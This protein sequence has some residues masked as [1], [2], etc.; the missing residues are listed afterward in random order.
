MPTA[1]PLFF[2]CLLVASASAQ[3]DAVPTTGIQVEPLLQ[4]LQVALAEERWLDATQSFETV[5]QQLHVQEDQVPGVQFDGT[6]HLQPGEHRSRAGARSQLRH[7]FQTAPLAFRQEYQRQYD[8]S[9]RR[10]IQSALQ[11]G[12]RQSVEALVSRYELCESSASAIRWLI[13]DAMAHGNWMAA[14]L[15]IQRLTAEP[16][17]ASPAMNLLLGEVWLRAGL[18]SE[19]EQAVRSA[20]RQAGFGAT[21]AW[22][23]R[24]LQLPNSSEAVSGWLAAELDIPSAGRSAQLSDQ[25]GIPSRMA[26]AWEISTFQSA[27]QPQLNDQLQL[28]ERRVLALTDNH[29][30]SPVRPLVVNDLVIC[31]A[32]G[33]LQAVNRFNGELVWESSQFNRQLLAALQLAAAADRGQR[34][35]SLADMVL[36]ESPRN[37]VRGQMTTDGRLLY[38]VEETTQGLNTRFAGTASSLQDRHQN[39]LRVYEVATGRLLG[40][41]GDFAGVDASA[42]TDPLAG[43]Y[44]LGAPL[45]LQD[46][47]LVLAED[48]HGIH[49]LDLR[50]QSASAEPGA[51]LR[52][53]I[54]DRQLLSIPLYELPVH[55]LRRLSGVTPR[56]SGGMI[57]CHVCDEQIIGLSAADL[58]IEWIYRYRATV[59]P[60][61]IGGGDPV[62]GNA[63]TDAESRSRDLRSRPHDSAVHIV[64]SHVLLMPRDSDQLVCVDLSTGEERWSWPRA[65]LR[66]VAALTDSMIVLAGASRLV[67]LTVADGKNVWRQDIS[68]TDVCAQPAATDRLVYL[69]TRQ[70]HVLAI[71]IESGRRL[72]NLPLAETAL[73]N[74]VSIPGQLIA[75]TAT[76]VACWQPA[77]MGDETELVAVEELLLSSEPEKAVER[78]TGMLATA[79]GSQLQEARGLLIEQLLESLRLDDDGSRRQIPLLRKLIADNAL[80]PQQIAEAIGASFG[81]TLNDS[82]LFTKKW[83]T[84]RQAGVHKSRLDRLIVQ[85]LATPE[86]LTLEDVVTQVSEILPAALGQPDRLI[87][88]GRVRLR[89]SGQ[90]AAAIQQAISQLDDVSRRRA[91]EQLRPLVRSSVSVH[92]DQNLWSD[93]LWFCWN[94][95]LADCLLPLNDAALD[96]LST[97]VRPALATQLMASPLAGWLQSEVTHEMLRRYWN[98]ADPVAAANWPSLEAL[99]T[100]PANDTAGRVADQLRRQ[101]LLSSVPNSPV[102][103]TPSDAHTASAE[104][105]AVHSAPQSLIPLRGTPGVFRGWHFVRQVNRRQILAIDADGRRRW[106]FDPATAEH[107]QI[108]PRQPGSNRNDYAVACGRLLALSDS[109]RLF[110]LNAAEVSDGSPK[111]LWSVQ[112]DQLLSPTSRHQ[113]FPRSW[114]RT[115][116]YDRQPDGLA[117]IGPLTEIGFPL[118][119]GDQLVVLNPWTGVPLWSQD[120]LPDDT[121]LAAGGGELCLISES[122]SRIQVRNLRDGSLRRTG[123][124][125]SWWTDGNALY[126]TSVRHV[127][128]EPNT[129][130]PWRIA[131]EET[132]CLTFLLSPERSR[133]ISWDLANV[134]ATGPPVAWQ[135][136]LS[137]DTVYS[138]VCDGL[139]ATLSDGNRLQ[140]R[141]LSD[142]KLT[143]DQ[144]VA[145]AGEC[146][147]LYLRKSGGR[148]LIL[149]NAPQ[150]EED[151]LPVMGA[152]AVNGPIYAFDE[153]D[154]SIAWTG[155]AT[156]ECLRILNANAM[157][158]LPSAPLLILLSRQARQSA[159][160]GIRAS[161]LA[162][163]IL[164]VH[165]GAVLFTDNDLGTNLSFH[166]LRFDG[167]GLFTVTFNR[168]SVEFDFTG[169]EDSP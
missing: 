151:V 46:R 122:T 168:R 167:D 22:G 7:I 155:R 4:G 5:W 121:R 64:G 75:Q 142:G 84:V 10:L 144:A 107:I 24:T 82:A 3:E 123:R 162:T 77:D 9:A 160:R 141:Q 166:G 100:G 153:R 136:E 27:V 19:S 132:D 38:C 40:Q 150:G 97:A 2:C 6:R 74:L 86:G 161:R 115:T 83:A 152:V 68:N 8:S 55:P 62:F 118:F 43:M 158:T 57:I 79:T 129:E 45:L 113:Q 145:P 96:E 92:S 26:P 159:E 49:L 44:F 154:G 135:A 94:A 149:T 88:S 51:E 112:L 104:R 102:R 91:I 146:D 108:R 119:R 66:H 14:A 33:T 30:L 53:V 85:G 37:H 11:R 165:D 128:L 143:I 81:L 109:G 63:T 99:T 80:T 103:V 130:I 138:N 78:L 39:V 21:V 164:N 110:M 101:R 28:L 76:G 59:R 124:L 65:E 147:H 98:R 67:A 36:R 125:P 93:Q 120:G 134:T 111:V 12:D 169:Q 35:L 47:V 148:L 127:D 140:V 29:P 156:G 54:A 60:K 25:A 157:P 117:P 50:F 52:P 131:V 163:R 133:L 31:Q 61:E 114:E 34:F 48:Q 16:A 89:A 41:A 71:E 56:F 137:S 90:K 69:P 87:R 18:E 58:S 95:G 1:R 23:S 20:V 72:L 105:R 70:G 116:M 15:L 73:G 32:V 126:D 17:A 13:S 139:I 42:A 106:E